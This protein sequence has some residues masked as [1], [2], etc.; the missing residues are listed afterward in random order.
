MS[1]PQGTPFRDAFEQA[2]ERVLEGRAEELIEVKAPLPM[3]ITAGGYLEKYGPEERYNYFRLLG[4]VPAP[5]SPVLITFGSVEVE[6]NLAFR[7]APQELADLQQQILELSVGVIEGADH[8]Y[9]SGRESLAET[10]ANWLG[11]VLSL[12]TGAQETGRNRT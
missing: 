1:A 5:A 12:P 2:R 9:T 4:N 3:L 7:G 10:L 11:R 6:N 8:F